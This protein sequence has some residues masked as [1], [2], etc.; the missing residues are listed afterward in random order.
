MFDDTGNILNVE[1]NISLM[2]IMNLG[3]VLQHRSRRHLVFRLTPIILLQNIIINLLT[4]K[5]APQYSVSTP[6]VINEE[7][8]AFVQ[9]T[10]TGHYN[11][12]NLQDSQ[13]IELRY[14]QHVLIEY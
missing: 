6:V 12:L 10:V 3:Q 9:N 11:C 7:P 2:V 14:P 1:E 5:P 8:V 13:G 4:K